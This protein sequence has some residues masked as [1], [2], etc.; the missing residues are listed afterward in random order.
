MIK[1][2][3]ANVSEQTGR[4]EWI[5]NAGHEPGAGVPIPGGASGE[6]GPG[7]GA[8]MRGWT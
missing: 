8:C 6:R 1:V 3:G 7:P 4:R 2:V 5:Q